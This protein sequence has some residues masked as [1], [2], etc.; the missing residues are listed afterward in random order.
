MRMPVP[1]SGCSSVRDAPATGRVD[2]PRIGHERRAQYRAGDG[3]PRAP[4]TGEGRPATPPMTQAAMTAPRR[5]AAASS[6]AILTT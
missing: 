3:R 1:G 5:C 4:V 2:D 6:A